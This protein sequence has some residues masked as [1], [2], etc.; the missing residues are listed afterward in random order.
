[1]GLLALR[2]Y[3]WRA[4]AYLQ[5]A[6]E[7]DRR[8]LLFNAVQKARVSTEGVKVME[9]LSECIGAR[10]FEAETYFESALREAQM[11]PGLE[12]ST[13]INFA[14]TAQFIGPYFADTHCGPPPSLSLREVP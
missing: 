7:H 13:H 2:L 8:Y 6:A 4:L 14:T 9:L 1:G 11:I 3:A 5:A 10:G 12:S